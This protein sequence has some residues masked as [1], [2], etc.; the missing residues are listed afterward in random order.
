VSEQEEV[1]DE[2]MEQFEAAEGIR[3]WED[4]LVLVTMRSMAGVGGLDASAA[5][6]EMGFKHVLAIHFV[7][8]IGW[9][10]FASVGSG[11]RGR[12]RESSET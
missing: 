3:R 6:E 5:E 10:M 7:S 1:G 2:D 9:S 12:R 8:R 11:S 4:G